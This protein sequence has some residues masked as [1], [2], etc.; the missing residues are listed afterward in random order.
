MLALLQQAAEP[1]SD[2]GSTSV[3]ARAAVPFARGV[4]RSQSRI[5]SP[6]QSHS[7]PAKLAGEILLFARFDPSLVPGLANQRRGLIQITAAH[8]ESYSSEGGPRNA[9]GRSKVAPESLP[10]LPAPGFHRREF[11]RLRSPRA[12]SRQDGFS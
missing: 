9:S 1:S 2:P 10:A 12:L 4:S 3:V 11:A 8:G 6:R 5:W 7:P